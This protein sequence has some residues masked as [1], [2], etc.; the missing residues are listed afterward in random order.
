VAL[1]VVLA[2]VAGVL[3][4]RTGQVRRKVDVLKA[5]VAT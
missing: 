4:R 5:V 2:A 1:Y 3:G